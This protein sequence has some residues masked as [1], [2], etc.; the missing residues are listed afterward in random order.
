MA[1]ASCFSTTKAAD[2]KVNIKGL[3]NRNV[4]LARYYAGKAIMIDTTLTGKDGKGL[5]MSQNR[6]PGLYYLVLPDRKSLEFLVNDNQ[7]LTLETTVYSPQASLTIKGTQASVDY[8][9]LNRF[10]LKQDKKC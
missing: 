2:I 7:D 4:F 5:F 9:L 3:A 8:L 10:L 1:M 6:D